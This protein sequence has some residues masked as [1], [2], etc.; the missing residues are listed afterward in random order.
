MLGSISSTLVILVIL[1]EP[2]APM[3]DLAVV[4][5]EFFL[6]QRPQRLTLC[7][8]FHTA[9]AQITLVSE[10]CTCLCLRA[11]QERGVI[12]WWQSLSFWTFIEKL[13]TVAL[14][15]AKNQRP[16]CE[17]A[18]MVFYSLAHA[19]WKWIAH[20]TCFMLYFVLLMSVSILYS[21][22]PFVPVYRAAIN[23]K[24][25]TLACL[26]QVMIYYSTG[27]FVP[28]VAAGSVYLLLACL[29]LL[30][31]IWVSFMFDWI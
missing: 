30:C 27:P 24:T 14:D 21:L 10:S 19:S 22:G 11:R 18:V 31:V 28:D 25:N 2:P 20:C 16:S 13:C 4:W 7:I 29:F 5:A 12:F 23:Q 9:L 3:C 6:W 8:I 17:N 1:A 26:W 15:K